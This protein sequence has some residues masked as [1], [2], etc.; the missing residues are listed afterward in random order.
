MIATAAP[1]PQQ[2]LRLDEAFKRMTEGQGTS[3]G[4][5]EKHI[6]S[7]FPIPKVDHQNHIWMSREGKLSHRRIY[8]LRAIA[9][10]NDFDVL[11]VYDTGIQALNTSIIDRHAYMIRPI[12]AQD[13]ATSLVEK[14]TRMG[15]LADSDGGPGIGIIAGKKPS[16]EELEALNNRQ[17]VFATDIVEDGDKLYA[18]DKKD[19]ITRLHRLLGKYLGKRSSEH[20]WMVDF[21]DP[22][23]TKRCPA[24]N[25]AIDREALH[26]MHCNNSLIKWAAEQFYTPADFEKED[27]ILAKHL[28]RYLLRKS[29]Y[30]LPQRTPPPQ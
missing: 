3:Y 20:R 15:G 23:G 12:M 16:S 14:W 21:D 26:C 11:T 27:P 19:R 8:S 25:S 6:C 10:P 17:R 2:A 4:L 5:G 29:A 7:I 30:G 28:K 24:C 13:I 22:S 9:K 1:A 18:S